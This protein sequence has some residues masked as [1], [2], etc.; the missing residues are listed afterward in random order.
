MFI[1][2]KESMPELAAGIKEI[3]EDY[4]RDKEE[5]LKLK[6]DTAYGSKY[7]IESVVDDV[8]IGMAGEI[9]GEIESIVRNYFQEN[10]KWQQECTDRMF[11]ELM[12]IERSGDKDV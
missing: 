8:S 12:E 7:A 10:I 4:M 9:N 1:S 5:K 11:T 3:V 2:L 6:I